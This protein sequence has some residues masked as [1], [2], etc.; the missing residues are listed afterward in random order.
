LYGV[1]KRTD[2]RD[3][4]EISGDL[5]VDFVHLRDELTNGFLM[6]G[7]H[8]GELDALPVLTTSISLFQL[9]YRYPGHR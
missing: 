2:R 4:R 5:G 8:V 1:Q 9:L 7:T 3:Y 6:L